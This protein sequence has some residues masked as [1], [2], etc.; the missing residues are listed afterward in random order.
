MKRNILFGLVTLL[1]GSLLAADS[2]PK[3][4][5]LAA[6]KKL[7]DKDNYSWRSI[8]D[9]GP[10]SPFTPAPT[11]GKTEKN[12]Y[13]SLSSTF[14][15]NTSEGVAKDKKVVVKT[16]EGWKTADEVTAG[17]GGGFD[18]GVFMAR[19]MQNLR[20]PA[21]DVEDLV[22]KVKELKKE[23]DAYAG[24][25]TEEG[26]KG[27]LTF[28]FGRRGGPP[29]TATDAKGSVKFWV[30]EGLVTKFES[31]VSGKRDFNGEEREI[32]RTVTV[33]IKDVGTTKLSV[34]EEAKKKL[35]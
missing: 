12:G 17:G 13:T 1:A 28:G 8:V 3:E 19:R 21:A 35:S 14:N 24:D 16:E 33:E 15:D 11:D 6:A 22:S 29:P 23:G 9:F 32:E 20:L 27:L 31:K 5:V 4:E 18:P 34:P 25:L 30:K 10:N 7:A 26:A 2:S